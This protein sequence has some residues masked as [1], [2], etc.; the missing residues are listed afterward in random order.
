MAIPA[1]CA[2]VA[3][4]SSSDGSGLRGPYVA[5]A[6]SLEV[7]PHLLHEDVGVHRHRGQADLAVEKL[8][9]PGGDLV[10]V[11]VHRHPVGKGHPHRR[12]VGVEARRLG[13]GGPAL[14]DRGVPLGVLGAD[15]AARL[16]VDEPVGAVTHHTPRAEHHLVGR[17]PLHRLDRVVPQLP[18]AHRHAGLLTELRAI[19]GGVPGGHRCP[20]S[21]VTEAGVKRR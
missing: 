17:L 10:V 19:V 20:R 4:K 2:V 3:M 11:A 21:I 12:Q 8:A 16:D 1:R 13:E 9:D 7:G 5:R 6:E 15:E 18:D 14:Q